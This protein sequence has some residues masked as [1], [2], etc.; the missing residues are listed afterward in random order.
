MYWNMTV[1]GTGDPNYKKSQQRLITIPLHHASSGPSLPNTTVL[2]LN[3]NRAHA[4]AVSM[5]PTP[6]RVI[7]K[8]L[9]KTL[10][11]ILCKLWRWASSFLVLICLAAWFYG[12][13]LPYFLTVMGFLS[14]FVSTLFIILNY[15][16]HTKLL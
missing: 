14:T 2:N 15:Y 10:L 8:T 12:G 1:L 3:A 6:T 9:L 16:L 5:L 4:I 7:V 13:F 11:Q